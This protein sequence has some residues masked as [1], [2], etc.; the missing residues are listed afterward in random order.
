MLPLEIYKHCWIQQPKQEYLKAKFRQTK[1]E[2]K[3]KTEKGGKLEKDY[4]SDVEK[5]IVEE[6][7]YF[8]TNTEGTEIVEQHVDDMY[9]YNNKE[10]TKQ[11]LPYIGD[12]G[13][14]LSLRLPEGA[15]P[16]IFFGQDKAIYWDLQ[17]NNNC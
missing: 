14:S 17:L 16:R 10:N 15:R 3:M 8:Y 5:Y 7:I 2:V 1:K 4:V 11:S 13:G 6:C 12:Y 9:T